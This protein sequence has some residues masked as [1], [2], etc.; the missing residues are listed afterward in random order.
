MS[1]PCVRMVCEH[2]HEY[3]TQGD[4]DS[5]V[6]REDGDVARFAAQV[7]QLR[8]ARPRLAHPSAVAAEPARLK[9]LERE[10]RELRMVNKILRKALSYFDRTEFDRRP[11]P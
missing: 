2:E 3:G 7:G 5:L 11:K 10:T 1:G 4:C 6:R 8:R 9:E